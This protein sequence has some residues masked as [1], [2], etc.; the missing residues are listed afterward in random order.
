MPTRVS[1]PLIRSAWRTPSAGSSIRYSRAVVRAWALSPGA[2]A[3]S[4]SRIAISA[5]AAEAFAKRS[6]RVAGVNSQLR[7]GV[8][9]WSVIGGFL[10]SSPEKVDPPAPFIQ[11]MLLA[12]SIAFEDDDGAASHRSASPTDRVH[13]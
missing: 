11:Y 12:S 3:S 4:R 2:T 10:S 5:P 1:S 8:A 13:H 6:G 9:A 7:V